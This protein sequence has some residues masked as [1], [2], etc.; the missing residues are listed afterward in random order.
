LNDQSRLPNLTTTKIINAINNTTMKMPVYTPMLKMVPITFHPIRMNANSNSIRIYSEG[1]FI[2]ILICSG[3]AE[4][5][6]Q[7]SE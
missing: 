7:A 1:C 5:N 4:F 2:P 6:S 3:Y